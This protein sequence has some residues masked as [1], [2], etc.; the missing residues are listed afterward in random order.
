MGNTEKRTKSQEKA[1]NNLAIKRR[2]H[3][4]I[5]KNCKFTDDETHL[6]CCWDYLGKFL[7]Q[8]LESHLRSWVARLQVAIVDLLVVETEI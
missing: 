1:N 8:T 4:T 2:K 5:G 6:L 7:K 3:I